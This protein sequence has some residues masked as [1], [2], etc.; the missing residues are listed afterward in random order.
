MRVYMGLVHYPVYNKNR[1]KIASSVTTLDVHDMARLA[2][3][4][5]VK[6]FY[7]ITPLK[8]QQRLIRDIIDHWTNGYGA[9]YNPDRKEAISL[10]RV[11]SFLEDGLEEIR[12]EEKAKPILIATDAN[13]IKD[14]FISYREA[15]D[16]LKKGIPVFLIFGTAWGLHEDVFK[17]ADYVLEPIY[18][19]SGYRHL[20]VRTAAAI[21][22]D[23]LLG[24]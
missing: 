20:S 15:K 8:E 1:E 13:V 10:V 6:G 16:I 5:D 9:R 4:Y 23:R 7:I 17:K 14:K 3:T 11:V 24:G 21:I 12:K 22:I 2:K 19:R 18:G